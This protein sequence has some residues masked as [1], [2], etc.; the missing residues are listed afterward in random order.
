MRSRYKVLDD[1][2]YFITSSIVK[3]IHIFSEEKYCKLIID[4]LIFRKNHH[5]LQL[6]GYVIM[7]NHIHLIISSKNIPGV[8]RSF[9]SFTAKKIIE[10]LI[11]DKKFKILD[12]LKL[13]KR[14]DKTDSEFQVW[15]EG[16]HPIQILTEREFD[17]ILEY[18]HFNP[19]SKELVENQEDW[20]YSSYNNYTGEG[21]IIMEIDNINE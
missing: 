10:L 21:E 20:K 2:L 11:K 1:G 17:Q 13:N 12:I 19:V 6:Y 8:M 5:K 4:D 14:I 9:K 7:P 16:Y 3:W 15:Q 18:I